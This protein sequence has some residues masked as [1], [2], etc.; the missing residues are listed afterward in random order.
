MKV[1]LSV[2]ECNPLKGSDSYVGWSYAVNMAKFNEVYALT[3]YDNKQDID[4]FCADNYIANIDKIHFIY[5]KQSKIWTD[6]LYKVNRYLGFLGSYFVWQRKAYKVA[7]KLNKS[8]EFD[9]CHHVSIA[10]FR[11]AGYL[12]KI[13]KLFIFGP[14]GGGQETPDSLKSYTV[15]HEK[16][17]KFR[18]FMNRLTTL[19][20]AYK[21]ALKKAK[22]VYSSNDETSECILKRMH[23]SEGSKLKQMTELCIDDKYLEERREL[24][25]GQNDIVRI[26]V[27][28]RLIYRKGIKL[29]LD[30]VKEI[31]TDFKYCVDIYGDGDQRKEL[32]KYVA[33]NNLSDRVLIHG[34]IDYE[35]MQQKY[36]EADIYVLPSLRES[37]GTAVVEAMAN[38]L[39][40]V[41]LNQNGV[42]HVVKNEAGILVDL[43]S[44]EQIITDMAKALTLLIETPEL[45]IRLGE[46]GYKMLEEKYTW[47]SRAEYMNSVYT[48]LCSKE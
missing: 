21:Q 32:E 4:K 46:A 19:M 29:L 11:C 15:G 17:E 48:S 33:D 40:V 47:S 39:P 27:S 22:L 26:L 38:K 3:R 10:D 35:L 41:S 2:F 43:I 7:K 8:V 42:K 5:V 13:G 31:N 37:T 6:Y 12:W 25:K 34:K 23:K 45:R 30:A 18:S 44:K 36:K 20:P 9:V 24:K 14:V 1:L 28:G 16:S